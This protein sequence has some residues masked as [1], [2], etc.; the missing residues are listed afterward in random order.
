MTKPPAEFTPYCFA[1]PRWVHSYRVIPGD[2]RQR[3]TDANRG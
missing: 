3:A 2:P 1:K